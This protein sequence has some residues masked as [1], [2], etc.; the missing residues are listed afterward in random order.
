MK[1]F[2]NYILPAMMLSGASIGVQSAPLNF[3]DFD[4]EGDILFKT[5]A[6]PVNFQ[7]AIEPM[8]STDKQSIDNALNQ[9]GYSGPNG[10]LLGSVYDYY[11]DMSHGKLHVTHEVVD[12]ITVS[13][14]SGNGNT[15]MTCGDSTPRD[16]LYCALE[17]ALAEAIQRDPNLFDGKSV[18]EKNGQVELVSYL[19]ITSDNVGQNFGGSTRHYQNDISAGITAASA[20]STSQIR[21]NTGV[22]SVNTVAHELGHSIFEW[23]DIY[24][25]CAVYD[26]EERECKE[27]HG[28]SGH[29]LMSSGSLNGNPSPIN[30]YFRATKKIFNGTTVEIAPS[31]RKTYKLNYN[32]GKAFKIYNPDNIK[33]F[34]SIS[35]VDSGTNDFFSAGQGTGLAIWHHTEKSWTQGRPSTDIYPS[36]DPFAAIHYIE[37]A[38]GL[39][40]LDQLRNNSGADAED[41]FVNG[42]IFPAP[43]SFREMTW[44]DSTTYNFT[45]ENIQLDNGYVLFDIIPKQESR[46][47]VTDYNSDSNVGPFI[48]SPECSEQSDC[49]EYMENTATLWNASN[50]SN[51]LLRYTFIANSETVNF[52]VLAD[53]NNN[54]NDSFFY[55][56]SHEASWHTQNNTQ[57]NGFE[58][59][60]IL[61]WNNLAPKEEYVLEILRREDGSKLSEIILSNASFLEETSV[62]MAVDF[63][64]SSNNIN[65]E[66]MP[67]HITYPNNGQNQI[68]INNFNNYLS[69]S[70]ITDESGIIDLTAFADLPN[71]GDDSFYYQIFNVD[72]NFKT[73]NNHS[74]NGMSPIVLLDKSQLA[75]NTRYQ[76]RIIEREDGA[77]ISAFLISGGRFLTPKRYN[78]DT[79]VAS[80][81]NGPKRIINYWRQNIAINNTDGLDATTYDSGWWS[82][83]WTLS[84]EGNDLYSIRNSWKGTYL[85]VNNGALELTKE[86]IG[87]GAGLWK[88]VPGWHTS[89]LGSNYRLQHSSDDTKFLHFQNE[90]FQYGE[91]PE[92]W[93]SSYWLLSNF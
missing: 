8:D 6:I 40:E 83:R 64:N 87:G 24:A 4:Q 51:G 80:H 7:D 19:F 60:D 70:F 48:Q 81:V 82:A 86:P 84:Y 89:G 36:K 47:S 37:Q 33:E 55:R 14:A 52:S 73:I 90:I 11:Q 71:G 25:T 17:E 69:Y 44:W 93:H 62:I 92:G 85:Q 68:N 54:S 31:Y 26:A 50:D 46:I 12:P 58:R 42:D 22:I 43:S 21:N 38:D 34:I 67:D 16:P 45:I 61:T 56:L 10:N 41:I 91:A 23:P 9:S 30:P 18:V 88:L 39:Y 1:L 57:T 63:Q 15:T 65:L 59:L 78:P 79:P 13:M 74:T 72:Q 29:A 28:M 3:V 49:Y 27:T 76:L 53:F 32:S 20:V 75:P 66:M 5:I 35:A 77:K 2:R